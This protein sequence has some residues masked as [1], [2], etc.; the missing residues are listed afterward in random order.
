[1]TSVL[2]QMRRVGLAVVA[3]GSIGISGTAFAQVTGTPSGDT[4]SNTA[5]V[6]YTVGTVAQAPITAT[7]AFTVDTVIRFTVT[8]T[9]AENVTPGQTGLIAAFTVDSASNISS[10]FSLALT[11]VVAPDDDFDMSNIVIRVDDG[12]GVYETS[13]PVATSITGLESVGRVVW[14]TSD[15]PINR[16]D[17]DTSNIRITATAINPSTSAAWIN[18]TGAD[19][20][21][22]AAQIVVANATAEDDAVYTVQ[23]ATL[24]VTKSSSVITDNLV[25]PSA[26]PK[27]IPGA[28]VEYQIL[29]QN[30]GSQP[31]T[32]NSISDP[33]PG[34]TTFATG[35][36]A[37]STDVSITVG[38][39][40]PTFCTVAADADG[41][42]LTGTTLTVGAPAI[43]SVAANS[44]VTVR[45]R[46]TIN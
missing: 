28:T 32:L 15:V 20:A 30:T 36:Y 24:A 6:N 14:V 22:G 16:L 21:G 42:T 9:S 3:L 33:V 31:A 2:K 4:V 26:N 44:T 35:Q 34:A 43:T 11:P 40:A 7:A 25:P 23:T 39:G 37:G 46:V 17:G 10:N 18:D 5:T 19:V 29:I 13:D 1:M 12:D 41:C 8:T 38:A 27:A 45:F